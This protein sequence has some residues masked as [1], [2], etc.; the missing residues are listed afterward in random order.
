MKK[1]IRISWKVA[2]LSF[3]LLYYFSASIVFMFKGIGMLVDR[4]ET[5]RN[6]H[7]EEEASLN[8]EE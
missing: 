6:F 3:K 2:N 8:G 1:I 5:H 4:T 7:D